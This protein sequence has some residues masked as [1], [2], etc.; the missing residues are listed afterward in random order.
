MVL[1]LDGEP[2]VEDVGFL[3]FR[4]DMVGPILGEGVELVSIVVHS[5]VP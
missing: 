1:Q 3:L 5:V 4:V 2:I